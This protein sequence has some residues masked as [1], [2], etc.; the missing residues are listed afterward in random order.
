MKCTVRKS[1]IS[2][3]ERVNVIPST[4]IV[5]SIPAIFCLD[6]FVE[7]L[8]MLDNPEPDGLS[9]AVIRKAFSLPS[10]D[11]KTKLLVSSPVTIILA[12]ISSFFGHSLYFSLFFVFPK[13]Q[14]S[15]RKMS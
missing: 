10:F 14:Q 11:F 13:N 15:A 1:V 4:T 9:V 8:S 12:V 7:E 2:F 6:E 5:A 3:E